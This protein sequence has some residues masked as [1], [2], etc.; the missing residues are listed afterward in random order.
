MGKPT[1]KS[2]L[3][4]DS[5]FELSN[6]YFKPLPISNNHRILELGGAFYYY[7]IIYIW[8][9]W[10]T[11]MLNHLINTSE[12]VS[13]RGLK[14][15]SLG[16][17][18]SFLLSSNKYFLNTWDVQDT[19]SNELNKTSPEFSRTLESRGFYQVNGPSKGTTSVINMKCC[20]VGWKD[21]RRAYYILPVI[22][23][24]RRTY[25]VSTLS[26]APRI[27][28]WKDTIIILQWL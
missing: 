19:E 27:Q 1:A 8:R 24:L 2:W 21:V 18:P 25:S 12:Q 20:H 26:L 14:S 11:E 4:I 15:T 9:N 3:F 5:I 13:G 10:D 22:S 7:Q 16:S 28:R 23:S 17:V 6:F